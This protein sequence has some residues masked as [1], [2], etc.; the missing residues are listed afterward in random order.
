MKTSA[1]IAM[2]L[3]SAAGTLKNQSYTATGPDTKIITDSFLK[4][5][6]L[7]FAKGSEDAKPMDELRNR[8]MRARNHPKV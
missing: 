6:K 3:S 8:S 4:E 7:H 1:T 2:L 5:D